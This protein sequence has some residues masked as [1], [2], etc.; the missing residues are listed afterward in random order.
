MGA[1][2]FVAALGRFMSIDPNEGGV[3]NAYDYPSDPINKSDLG[4]TRTCGG[5]T[6]GA[7]S[8]GTIARA[9][10]QARLRSEQ[11]RYEALAAAG[12][13]KKSWVYLATGY[14]SGEGGFDLRDWNGKVRIDIVSTSNAFGELDITQYHSGVAWPESRA[15]LPGVAQSIYFE[16]RGMVFAPKGSITQSYFIRWNQAVIYEFDGAGAT[17]FDTFYYD[18]YIWASISDLESLR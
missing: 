7:L 6:C 3:T 15:T 8:A 12:R 9:K 4:G 13:T 10:A 17:A 18:V 14:G 5:G 16:P 11:A 1:R 2:V